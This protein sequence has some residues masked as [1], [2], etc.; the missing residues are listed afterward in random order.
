MTLTLRHSLY[1]L[2]QLLSK[3]LKMLSYSVNKL[4]LLAGISVRTL[5]FYDQIGLLQPSERTSSKYR[6]YSE[7]ELLKLQQILF[8]KE[9]NFPLKE[10]S[11]ILND[12]NFN[13]S[14][15]LENHKL[16][17]KSKRD[18]IDTLLSTID[19]TILKL[20]KNTMLKDEELYEG[21]PKGKVYREEAVKKYGSEAIK[22][23]E[24][25]L[26]G[27]GKEG[28]EKLKNESKEV[29]EILI[30]LMH[31]D[32]ETTKVQDQIARHYINIRKFWGTINMPDPQAEAYKG[33]GQLYVSDIRFAKVEGEPNAEFALF[34]SKAMAYFADTK[35]K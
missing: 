30:S 26:K 13:L 24:N 6:L 5:H 31:E 25:Y 19:K 16:I 35:L 17:L 34:M 20:N 9:L 27:L 3:N 12:P 11:K 33:L 15:A 2:C 28:F 10:I 4:A 14:K 29:T 21:F 8:Y 18:R 32:P 22:R 1:C 23:S 7:K